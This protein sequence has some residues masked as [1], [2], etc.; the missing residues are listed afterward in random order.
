MNTTLIGSLWVPDPSCRHTE[1]QWYQFASIRRLSIVVYSEVQ[2]SLCVVHQ[3]CWLLESCSQKECERVRPYGTMTDGRAAM[4]QPS[5]VSRPAVV[6]GRLVYEYHCSWANERRL[7]HWRRYCCRVSAAICRLCCHA[8]ATALSDFAVS[9]IRTERHI[10]VA[11]ATTF[12]VKSRLL[13]RCH[14]RTTSQH[15]TTINCQ[16]PCWLSEWG[17]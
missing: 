13:A 12:Q 14:C 10:S 16:A 11:S 4:C 1:C 5:E 6:V 17:N 8:S 7:S 2:M 15:C 3:H 9:E